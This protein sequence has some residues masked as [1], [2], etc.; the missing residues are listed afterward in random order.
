MLYTRFTSFLAVVIFSNTYSTANLVFAED[1]KPKGI[2]Q[3]NVFF[4]SHRF[5]YVLSEGDNKT[6]TARATVFEVIGQE[7]V[8]IRR[9]HQMD[10]VNLCRPNAHILCGVGRFLITCDEGYMWRDA[11][12][13]ENLLVVYDLVR[14]EKKVF[15]FA[16]IFTIDFF[17][18]RGFENGVPFTAWR[19]PFGQP[20]QHFDSNDITFRMPLPRARIEKD[21]PEYYEL[22]IDLLG[23]EVELEQ[24][25]TFVDIRATQPQLD[26]PNNQFWVYNGEEQK[27]RLPRLLRLTKFWGHEELVF[28]LNQT[29][30]EYQQVST[31]KWIDEIIVADR[32]HGPIDPELLKLLDETPQTQDK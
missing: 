13:V 8:Q 9:L 11:V 29:S 20:Q 15:R 3:F 17:V 14:K 22:K 6:Q 23:R 32:C 5:F 18:E 10:L 26:W 7:S 27:S 1:A 21:P 31:D 16:D 24:V 25:E 19:Q 2:A 30:L 12:D 28:E 4:D